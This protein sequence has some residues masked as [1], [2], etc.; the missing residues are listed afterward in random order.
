MI[1][2][3]INQDQQC[4]WKTHNLDILIDPSFKGI[5]R[6]FELRFEKLCTQNNSWKIPFSNGSNKKLQCHIE[7]IF[8]TNLLEMA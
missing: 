6:L 2:G 5:I 8:M 4:K 1:W 7:E 3:N